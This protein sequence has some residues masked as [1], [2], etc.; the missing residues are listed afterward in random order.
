MEYYIRKGSIGTDSKAEYEK[1]NFADGQ[2]W[3]VH[4]MTPPAVPG[5]VR[6]TAPHYHEAPEFTLSNVAS[7]EAVVGRK[8]TSF[9]GKT[10]FYVPP[11]CVHAFS[12]RGDGLII[13]AK[14]ELERL[15]KYLDLPAIFPLDSLTAA[16]GD[17]DRIKEELFHIAD[18][19]VSLPDRLISVLS[20]FRLL[21]GGEIGQASRERS[22]S[23]LSGAELRSVIDWTEANLHQPIRLSEIA[24]RLG[25]N[26]NYFCLKFKETNGETYLAYVTSARVSRA[27]SLLAEGLSVGAVC[28]ACGFQNESYFIQL[29]TK[30]IGVT[31][32]RYQRE[33]APKA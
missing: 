6:F 8:R 31:P 21:T 32:K 12:Y 25:Y 14:L 29:F 26:P 19:D 9:S 1:S 30:R 17:H 28:D 16:F 23:G 2:F 18:S 15:G 3:K 24:A 22:K 5:G 33:F 10:V 20:I 27:C 13:G 7:V 4:I 11:N